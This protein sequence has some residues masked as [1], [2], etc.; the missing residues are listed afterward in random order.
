MPSLH[1]EQLRGELRA[2][3]LHGDD[4]LVEAG[5]AIDRHRRGEASPRRSPTACSR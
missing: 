2:R 3:I 4:A 1:A 5:N